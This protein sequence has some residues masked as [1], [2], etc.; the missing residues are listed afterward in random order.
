MPLVCLM[1]SLALAAQT[2]LAVGAELTWSDPFVTTSG[3]R[4]SA[5]AQPLPWLAVGVSGGV[6]PGRGE[7]VWSPLVGQ[8]VE[9]L[10][11]S[12]ELSYIRARGFG[13]V[14]WIPL[15]VAGVGASHSLG[16]SLGMGAVFTED[17]AESLQVP[18][19][20]PLYVAHGREWHPAASA[21]LVGEVRWA[22]V[23][24][25]LR[26]ERLRYTEVMLDDVQEAKS[27]SWIGAEI[28]WYA[29]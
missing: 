5:G 10:G 9:E 14:V 16:V 12:P 1:S 23:G 21:G 7:G 6:Y 8:L 13:E 24:A 22:R 28:A 17:D 19:Q 20:D 26:L 29:R 18:E 15:R 11:V 27:P 4:V 2:L 25:R 3:A